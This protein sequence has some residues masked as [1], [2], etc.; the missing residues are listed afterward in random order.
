MPHEE[1]GKKAISFSRDMEYGGGGL[2]I[3]MST[4]TDPRS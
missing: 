1:D 3:A 4:T 2:E